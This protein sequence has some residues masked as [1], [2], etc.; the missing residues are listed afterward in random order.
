[1]MPLRFAIFMVLLVATITTPILAGDSSVAISGTLRV[2][3]V[4]LRSTRGIDANVDRIITHLRRLAVEGVEVAVFPECAV[5]GYFEDEATT[6]TAEQLISAER[7]IASACREAGINAIVGTPY[8]DGESL[9]NSA[10]VIDSRGRVIERYHKVQLAEPWPTPG[11]HLSVF[12]VEGVPCSIIICH[13]E[14]YPELVRLPVL[15]GA[16]VVFYLSHESGIRQERKIGPYRAQ[17]QARAVENSVFVVHANAPADDDLGGSHGQSRIIEPDGT[18]VEEASMFEEETVQA[19]L[20]LAR[21]SA[22]NALRSLTRGPLT[23]WW[24]E[25]I[26]RVRIIESPDDATA[27]DN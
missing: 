18:I 12:P 5:T 22:A 21:A 2:A 6:A 15:A 3:A 26:R 23:D 20:D 1:M 19:E 8:R 4:Q 17:I 11:D 14:R 9:T 25:G 27:G 16:R 13:D 7:R 10:V 24:R